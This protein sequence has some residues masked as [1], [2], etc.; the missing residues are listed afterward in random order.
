MLSSTS[1]G[2]CRAESLQFIIPD[3]KRSC[4]HEL[5]SLQQAHKFP[6]PQNSPFISRAET[7]RR[8]SP[9]RSQAKHVAF[10]NSASVFSAHCSLWPIGIRNSVSIAG[11]ACCPRLNP[12]IALGSRTTCR[13]FPETSLFLKVLD[14]V[15]AARC[16][17]HFCR[18]TA[19]RAATAVTI[20]APFSALR[21]RCSL[22]L[23][24]LPR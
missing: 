15:V 17:A 23:F 9:I 12:D 1:S 7:G 3:S 21:P 8:I 20:F 2:C 18:G 11:K 19:R 24:M 22:L 13:M 14:V 6:A 5:A 16:G 4:L 10:N